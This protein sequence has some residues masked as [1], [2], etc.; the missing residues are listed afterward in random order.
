MFKPEIRILGFDDAPFKRTDKK[1][2]VIGVIYRGGS[3]LDVVLKT[4][5]SVDGLD[6]TERLIKLIN[7]SRHKPQLKVLMFDGI[8]LGGFNIIDVKQLY[9]KVNLP[10]IVINRKHPNLESVKYA[11]KNNFADFGKRW[12]MILNAGKIKICELR[13]SKKVYYQAVGLEDEDAEEVIRLSS[14][15]GDIPEPLRVAH[16][17]ATAIVKGESSGRA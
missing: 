8:T 15:H 2:D 14:T 6:A 16:L 3:F 17:I 7:N 11:L 9:R 1:V 13:D 12:K 4:E 10:I 5:V